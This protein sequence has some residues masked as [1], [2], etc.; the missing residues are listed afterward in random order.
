ME[1]NKRSSGSYRGLSCRLERV[2]Q[3]AVVDSKPTLGT[4]YAKNVLFDIRLA[5]TFNVA[6]P[7]SPFTIGNANIFR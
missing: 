5:Q 3:Q 4:V 6:S 2:A 7:H 1:K